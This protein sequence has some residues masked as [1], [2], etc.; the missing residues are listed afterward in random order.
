MMIQRKQCTR[1]SGTWS[2]G[3]NQ[4]YSVT[5]S[6]GNLHQVLAIEGKT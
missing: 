3:G 1:E 4:P 6:P 5:K 2:G